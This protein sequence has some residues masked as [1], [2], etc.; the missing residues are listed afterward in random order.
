VGDQNI[1][2]NQEILKK[3]GL[4]AVENLKKLIGK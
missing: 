4:K 1:P 3:A 2:A